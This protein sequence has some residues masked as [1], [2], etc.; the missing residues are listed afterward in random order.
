VIL[1]LADLDTMEVAADVDE[2]DVVRVRSG[3]RAKVR[4]DAWEDSTLEAAVT[5]VGLSPRQA[6]ST[7]QQGTNFEV[8]ARILAPPEGLR[9]GM[10]ADVEILTGERDSALVVPIQALEAHPESVVRKWRERGAGADTTNGKEEG[11]GRKGGRREE[12][13]EEEP[14][15][16]AAAREAL[17]EGVFVRREGKARFV[18]VR[19]GLRGDTRVEVRADLAAGDEIV[20][21]PYRALR[22]LKD[23][24]AV[25]PEKPKGRARTEEAE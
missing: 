2:T 9:P 10:N 14:D 22:R 17:V 4:V 13:I 7:Q 12:E 11:G 3:Q 20:S 25:R 19:L 16:V 1:V 5:A 15:S 6:Q 24:D 21:G 18:P 23:G 8:R